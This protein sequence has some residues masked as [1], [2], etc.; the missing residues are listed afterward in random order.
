MIMNTILEKLKSLQRYD[1]ESVWD[2]D[3]PEI[4]PRPYGDLVKWQ[5]IE[6]IIEELEKSGKVHEKLATE[7]A[8]DFNQREKELLRPHPVPIKQ[9]EY[10]T[11]EQL[12]TEPYFRQ[13]SEQELLVVINKGINHR[14]YNNLNGD[15][16]VY[17]AQILISKWKEEEK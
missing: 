6:A 9:G 16:S 3:T 11:L 13:L 4:E 8:E 12:L 5:D 2:M 7:F 17:K 15:W 14:D 1:A 10:Y